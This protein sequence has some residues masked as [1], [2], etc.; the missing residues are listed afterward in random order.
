MLITCVRFD[1]HVGG[2]DDHV[3]SFT[4]QVRDVCLSRGDVR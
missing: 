3:G 4:G 1:D 2:F